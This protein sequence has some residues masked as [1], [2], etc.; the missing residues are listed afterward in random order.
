MKKKPKPATIAR[1]V[2]TFADGHSHSRPL[3]ETALDCIR[4]WVFVEAMEVKTWEDHDSRESVRAKLRRVAEL[5]IN[6]EFALFAATEGGR[7]GGQRGTRSKSKPILVEAAKRLHIGTAEIAAIARK[8]RATKR[9]V[10][11]TLIRE[12]RYVPQKKGK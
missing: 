2:R 7:K 11:K 5:A 9:T 1:D 6:A 4:Q 10:R 3:V 8:A 12:G